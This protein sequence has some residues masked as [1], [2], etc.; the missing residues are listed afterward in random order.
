MPECGECDKELPTEKGRRIHEGRMH[1][2]DTW[3][4]CPHCGD[5]FMNPDARER[6]EKTRCKF[7][8]DNEDECER[9]GDERPS[10]V[11]R[12]VP[13]GQ[14]DMCDPCFDEV[15]RKLDVEPTVTV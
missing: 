7:N 13:G 6:H 1:D 5:Q 9:C 11:T 15:A 12:G 3:W 8:P 10:T 14:M 2:V 4:K